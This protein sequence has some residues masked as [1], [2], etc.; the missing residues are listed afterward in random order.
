MNEN[1]LY[2]RNEVE[3]NLGNLFWSVLRHW[4]GIIVFML[5]FGEKEYCRTGRK[6]DGEPFAD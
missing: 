4:R 3:I 5:V 2:K 6:K 1:A